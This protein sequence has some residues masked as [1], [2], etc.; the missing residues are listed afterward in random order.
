MPRAKPPYPAT[1]GLW[2]RPTTVHNVETLACVPGIAA[3]GAQWFKGLAA[4]PEG[5]TTFRFTLAQ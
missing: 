1:K 2:G 4:N 5:G 3:H